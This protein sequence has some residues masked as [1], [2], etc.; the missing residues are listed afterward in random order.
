MANHMTQIIKD[1]PYRFRIID[2]YS[3]EIQTDVLTY[4]D[5]AISE[6]RFFCGHIYQ[7][8]YHGKCIR[9]LAKP[10]EMIL[11]IDKIQV[12]QFYISEKKLTE[13]KSE[14][15]HLDHIRIP[16][17]NIN[18][19]WVSLDGHTRLKYLEQNDIKKV[20]CYYDEYDPYIV[21]FVNAAKKKKLFTIHDLPIISEEEYERKWIAYCQNYFKNKT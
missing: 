19:Q 21:D 15:T 1:I 17:A 3:A 14:I 2:A 18:N 11:P 9:T 20:I 8:Y 6:F 10:Q 13:V 7:F 5:E 16:I 12:S 4:L